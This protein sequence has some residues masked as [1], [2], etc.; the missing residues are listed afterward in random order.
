M[1]SEDVLDSNVI[2]LLNL[3][4]GI[5]KNLSSIESVRQQNLNE[6]NVMILNHFLHFFSMK[7][8]MVQN[9]DPKINSLNQSI[10]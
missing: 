4:F 8:N 9:I 7:N 5:L 6:K 1:K 2:E 3:S 10:I